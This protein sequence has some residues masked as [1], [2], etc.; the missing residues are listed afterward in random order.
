MEERA[1]PMLQL[2][3]LSIGSL[4]FRYSW[5]I[6]PVI[7]VGFLASL[8]WFSAAAIK[9]RREAGKEQPASL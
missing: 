9:A 7:A 6:A 4:C 5:F 3:L 8:T 2:L 1:L